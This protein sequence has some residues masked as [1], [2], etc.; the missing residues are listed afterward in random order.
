MEKKTYTDNQA[1]LIQVKEVAKRTMPN[2]PYHNFEHVMDVYSVA[3]KYGPLNNLNEEDQFLL[4]SAVLLHDIIYVPFAQDNE[5]K[6]MEFARTYLS[7]LDYSKEQINKIKGMILA[8]KLP[9]RPLNLL[10]KIICDADLDN[11]GREDF[12]EKG[13]NFRNELGLPDNASWYEKTFQFIS[14]HKY[15][16]EPAKRLREKKEKENIQKLIR[17]IE[18]VQ[19]C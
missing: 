11:F 7:G 10:E 17:K 19:R 8:T 16:T 5:E 13:N 3:K 18:E 2:L 15:Y 1:K 4:E 14:N 9:Q 12:F 6:S